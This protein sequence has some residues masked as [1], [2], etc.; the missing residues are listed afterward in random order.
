[1]K[2]IFLCLLASFALDAQSQLDG[3]EYQ[4]EDKR[5]KKGILIQTSAVEDSPFRAVRGEMTVRASV[6][7]LVALVEDLP[8]CPNWA[9][10][11]KEAYLVNRVSPTESY[12]YIYN[13][14]PFPVSDRDVHSHVVWSVDEESGKE[15]NK[16]CVADQSQKSFIKPSFVLGLQDCTFGQR[17]QEK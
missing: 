16:C 15:S 8:A 17:N 10:L 2:R 1:M 7:S 4:W 13:D 5:N 14:V 3:V 12:A 9:D 11:C 6:S